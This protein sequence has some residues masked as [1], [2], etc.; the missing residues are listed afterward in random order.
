MTLEQQADTLENRRKTQRPWHGPP[1]MRDDARDRYLFTASCLNHQP[2]I[3]HTMDRVGAFEE[4]LLEVA[5]AT[6]S[7]VFAWVVLPNHYHMLVQTTDCMTVLAELG[8]LH[9]RTSFQWNGEEGKRGRQVWC[10]AAE[11]VMK[12]DSH[13]WA[14]V[15][16]LHHN[17]VKHGYTATWQ[18]WPFSSAQRYLDTLGKDEAARVWRKYP[19][20]T[21]GQGWDD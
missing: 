9:G 5:K 20:E 11:T 19:V 18:E 7:E 21:Y 17:P 15:N 2:V 4:A 1:H 6:C 10:N 12:S 16:Y 8:R 14:T 3:G 13:F